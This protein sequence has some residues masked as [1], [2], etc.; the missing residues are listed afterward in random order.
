MQKN[1]RDIGET[2]ATL[3]TLAT[4]KFLDSKVADTPDIVSDLDSNVSDTSATSVT[5][6]LCYS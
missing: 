3:A 6:L 1:I 2:L 5:L 4:V